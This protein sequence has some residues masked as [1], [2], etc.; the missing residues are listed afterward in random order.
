[1]DV[2]ILVFY[3]G[4]FWVDLQQQSRIQRGWQWVHNQGA[5]DGVCCVGPAQQIYEPLY[6]SRIQDQV[7]LQM[8]HY[9]LLDQSTFISN[10]IFQYIGQGVRKGLSLYTFKIKMLVT[11]S[12]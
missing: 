5:E 7:G 9:L 2:V 10:I 11:F 12:F 1:M 4:G 3:S 6:R 8:A